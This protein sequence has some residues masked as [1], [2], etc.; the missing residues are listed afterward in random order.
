MAYRWNL[1][2]VN[3]LHGNAMAYYYDQ[4]TNAYAENGDTT[5]AASYVRDC[6]LDHI[7]YG[8]TD[9]N[10][11][12]GHAPD[13]V[14]F[15]TGDRCLAGTCDPIEHTNAANWPDVPYDPGLLRVRAPPARSP[16]RPS[17]RRSG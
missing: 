8:F 2:Y 10:A 6:H 17:G 7:D 16:A 14:S 12:T 3:D 5:S 9:G 15:A 4:D 13:E 11:Y 1:D